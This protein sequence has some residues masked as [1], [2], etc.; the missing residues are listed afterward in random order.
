L[1]NL[2]KGERV[3]SNLRIW[4]SFGKTD[5]KY[6]KKNTQGGRSSTSITPVYMVKKATEALGQIGIGWGYSVIEERFDNTAPIVLKKGSGSELPVYMTDNGAIV[7]EKTHT[8]LLELWIK[9]SD[10]TF[11]QY[12]HTRYTYM[13]KSGSLYVD[14]EYGKKS[15]TDAMTKCLSLIGVCADVY[16]GEFDDR[17]YQ[18]AAQLENDLK[19]AD[20]K[21]AEYVSKTQ[22]LH[23][24]IADKVAAMELCPNFKA[25]QSVYGLAAQKIDREAPILGI[26]PAEAKQSLDV[27]YH[28]MNNQF[29]KESK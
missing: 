8:V 10:K 28:K 21:D 1:G 5:P 18:Q 24:Y 20:D 19:K 9:G 29:N 22:Q 25:M 7:Y 27:M 11:S 23:S 26:D 14:H 17:G 12:G 13:T 4:D 2:A 3:M 6:T 16:M 15:I